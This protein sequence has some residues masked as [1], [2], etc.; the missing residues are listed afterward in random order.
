MNQ[1]PDHVFLACL[2]A[3]AAPVAAAQAD[4]PVKTIRI[5]HG[6]TP[7]GISDVLACSLGAKLATS[8]GQQVVVDAR[9]A[10]PRRSARARRPA[11][12]P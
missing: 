3:L 6:F 4:Y 12:R 5:V 10:S 7:G 2:L 8:F 9:S 11:C 1:D